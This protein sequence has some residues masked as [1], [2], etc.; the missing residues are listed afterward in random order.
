MSCGRECSIVLW[1]CTTACYRGNEDD[2]AGE[3]TAGPGSEGDEGADEGPAEVPDGAALPE[4]A[5]SRLTSARMRNTVRDLFAAELAADLVLPDDPSALGWKSIGAREIGSSR[6]DVA[7]YEVAARDIAAWAVTDPVWIARWP[8]CTPLAASDGACARALVEDIG[9]RLF[10]RPLQT[11]EIERFGAVFDL[12][13]ATTG[14]FWAAFEYPL[15]AMLLSPHFTHVIAS[16]ESDGGALRYSDYEIATRLAYALWNTTPDDALLTAAGQGR[17]SDVDGLAAE[18]ER[19]TA[20]EARMADGVHAF[21]DDLFELDLVTRA[22]LDPERFADADDGLLAAMRDATAA[23]AVETALHDPREFLAVIEAGFAFVDG[24]LAPHYGQLVDGD[25]RVRIELDAAEVH[26]GLL[27]EPGMLAAR[28]S[29]DVTSPTR[30][31]RFVRTRMLCQAIPDPP[32]GIE[33]GLPT[34]PTGTTRRQQL[35]SHVEDPTC[36][37]CHTAMDPIGFGLEHFDASG[38]VQELDNGAPIDASGELD[39]V[40]FTDARGLSRALFEHPNLRP[41]FA[42]QLVRWVH[43]IEP[44]AD[45]EWMVDDVAQS[46]VDHHGDFVALMAAIASSESFRWAESLRD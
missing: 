5:M 33:M 45:H 13:A 3:P 20:D 31:G 46:Y 40:A 30:R 38:R 7:A 24:R 8:G 17:L 32:P 25:A 36:A 15:A 28:S 9:L 27:T 44:G 14:E 1:L 12:A 29:W 43:G 41:C 37:A 10:R 19:M 42:R 2:P 34:A 22:R 39:G 35:A 16:G 4:I 21:A 11:E 6:S 23:L 18:V 26:V